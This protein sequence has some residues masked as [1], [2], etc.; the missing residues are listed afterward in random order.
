MLITYIST[1][2]KKQLPGLATLILGFFFFGHLVFSGAYVWRSDY[3][4]QLVGFI[5]IL[6]MVIVWLAWRGLMRHDRFPATGM[7]WAFGLCL[8]VM[9]IS[10]GLSS[11]PRQGLERCLMLLGYVLLFYLLA[12][13]L[14]CGLNGQA[15]L[16]A[17]LTVSGLVLAE[18]VLETYL[19]Y[20]DWW[21]TSGFFNLPPSQYRF[22]GFLLANPTMAMGILLVGPAVMV[23][24]KGKRRV[25]RLSGGIWLVFFVLA[26]PFSSARSAWLGLAVMGGLFAL[27]WAWN[28]KA[29]LAVKYWSML[30]KTGL[31][32]ALVA[33]FSFAAWLGVKFLNIFASQAS[34][35][36]NPFG[37][38]GRFTFW[39]TFFLVWQRYPWFGTGPG[40]L[41][42][43]FLRMD[44]SVP[45]S[46]W[47]LHAHNIFLQAV[48]EFGLAGLAALLFL[49][50]SAGICLWRAWSQADSG[51][52]LWIM[53][54]T[55]SFAG[56]L[57]PAQFEEFSSFTLIPVT[58]VSLLCWAICC[59]PSE[60]KTYPRIPAAWLG[61]PAMALLCGFGFWLW[62]YQPMAALPTLDSAAH[63]HQAAEMV[64][65]SAER[66]PAF[67][68]YHTEA[69]L[70]WAW[71]WKNEHDPAALARARTELQAALALESSPSWTWANLAVLDEAAGDG[72][73]ALGH[74][75]KA[76]V[77][78]NSTIP[79]RHRWT[80]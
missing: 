69:G 38:S 46:Y 80:G 19:W 68:Y 37:D 5:F 43:E 8:L 27:A 9:G 40:R 28:T 62:A 48:G 39:Q 52:K 65:A 54:I 78:S 55:L 12:N 7:E 21:N 1:T 72:A 49:L 53:A 57:V 63:L 45:F 59:S 30:K 25:Y 51:H 17:L 66:D 29:W 3:N 11:D 22:H 23:F 41:T 44:P 35:G 77:L 34:H 75:Q 76:I 60:A 79:S 2:L 67:H 10:W 36:F 56:F 14:R 4:L 42:I 71:T 31:M 26:L 73:A 47:P 20:L 24:L 6:F 58:A 33:G 18:A 64:S 74:M 16:A 13:L 70:L 32:L 15:W 50:A 61:L